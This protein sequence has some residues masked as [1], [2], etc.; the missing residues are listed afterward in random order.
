MI[1]LVI[2]DFGRRSKFGLEREGRSMFIYGMFGERWRKI[3]FDFKR[4]FSFK[5]K[6]ERFVF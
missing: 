4:E 6:P 1:N 5:K 2:V 3:R